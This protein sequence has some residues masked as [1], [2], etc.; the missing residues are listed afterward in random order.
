MQ[1]IERYGVILLVFLMVT[2]A[3]VAFWRSPDEDSTAG[4]VARA[5]G[6]NSAQ[7]AD[8]EARRREA[9][10]RAEAR[11]GRPPGF[12][13]PLAVSQGGQQPGARPAG[14]AP[15]GARA[16]GQRP[17]GQRPPGQRPGVQAQPA[18][19]PGA[20]APQGGSALARSLP[21]QPQAPA[22]G[23]ARPRASHAVA[24]RTQQP[25]RP[26]QA[27][28]VATASRTPAAA[29]PR[30]ATPGGART[31]TVRSGDTLG[32]LSQRHLGTAT[33]WREISDMNG[34]LDPAALRVGMELRMPADAKAVPA[35]ATTTRTASAS[36]PKNK[37][38]SKPS[39][40]SAG[41]SYTIREGDSL[42]RIASRELG[43]GARYVELQALNPKA[44]GTLSVGDTIV[45]PASARTALTRPASEGRRVAAVQPR[46]GVVR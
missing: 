6:G 29:P 21:Q 19:A 44:T 10:R 11:G 22:A 32:E 24:T 9:L 1:P 3:V 41:R 12:Q 43:D 17:P 26:P 5:P 14:A 27:P 31:V 30:A 42:W 18:S 16:S 46:R 4:E 20:Q 35:S 15:A 28:R 8:Q 25:A 40:P 23:N 13:P 36:K 39:A 7:P 38:K 34:G 33:R 2:I 45:L 37:P